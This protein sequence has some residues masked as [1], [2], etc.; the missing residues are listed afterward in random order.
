MAR[1]SWMVVSCALLVGV[2][3]VWATGCVGRGPE[4]F[5]MGRFGNRPV[6]KEMSEVLGRFLILRSQLN[7]TDEQRAKIKEIVQGHS[8]EIV[9]IA[10]SIVEKNRAL[11]RAVLAEAPDDQAIRRAADDLGK[12]IGDAAVLASSV[13]G[14]TR[15]VM[16]AE[17]IGK[18]EEFRAAKDAA[19]DKLLEKLPT[20]M[21][22]D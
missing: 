7:V 13:R 5:A 1:K 14:Q 16:T 18:I 20:L 10:K 3:A 22:Q 9:P 6:M 12:A 17:Q 19:V 15:K 2:A 8:D 11:R 21:A 4:A